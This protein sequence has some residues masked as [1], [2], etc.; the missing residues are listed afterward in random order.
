MASSSQTIIMSIL[1]QRQYIANYLVLT[2]RKSSNCHQC[3]TFGLFNCQASFLYLLKLPW[4]VMMTK[5]VTDGQY[6]RTFP[7]ESPF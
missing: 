3:E 6:L 5:S 4:C 2:G 7:L 1:H